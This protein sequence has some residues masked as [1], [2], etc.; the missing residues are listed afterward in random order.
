MIRPP[1]QDESQINASRYPSRFW[2]CA[3]RY[4]ARS[5]IARNQEFWTRY[6]KLLHQHTPTGRHTGITFENDFSPRDIEAEQFQKRPRE[7]IERAA[8]E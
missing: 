6:L 8:G 2:F 4:R 5:G 1:N 3:E 7:I